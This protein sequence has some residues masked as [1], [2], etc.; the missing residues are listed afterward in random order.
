MN[1]IIKTGVIKFTATNSRRERG[2]PQKK[3]FFLNRAGRAG[4]V[5][6]AGTRA[7]NFMTK[8]VFSESLSENL[9]GLPSAVPKYTK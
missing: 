4:G 3:V 9:M 2:S 1:A 8:K 6:Q 7:H 5:S